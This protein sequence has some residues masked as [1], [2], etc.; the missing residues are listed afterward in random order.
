MNEYVAVRLYADSY[1]MEF[2]IPDWVGHAFFDLDAPR[3]DPAV[4]PEFARFSPVTK[5]DFPVRWEGLDYLQDF[6]VLTR[7]DILAIST[8]SFAAPPQP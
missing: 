2:L 6:H 5:D 7:S 1:G 8:G 4:L 3:L